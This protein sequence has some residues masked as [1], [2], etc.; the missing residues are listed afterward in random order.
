MLIL[1]W[2]ERSSFSDDLSWLNLRGLR[3][4]ALML[5]DESLKLLIDLAVCEVGE[6]IIKDQGGVAT[7]CHQQQNKVSC[8]NHLR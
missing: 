5:L 2:I 6:Q 1:D 7:A 3:V 8:V 4:L